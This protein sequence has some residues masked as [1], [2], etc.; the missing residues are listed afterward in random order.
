VSPLAPEERQRVE[1]GVRREGG[2]DVEIAEQD[3]LRRGRAERRGGRRAL[4]LALR[5]ARARRDGARD[6][7]GIGLRCC[8]EVSVGKEFL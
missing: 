3:L 1:E 8:E 6:P 7:A 5:D 4:G 2:V